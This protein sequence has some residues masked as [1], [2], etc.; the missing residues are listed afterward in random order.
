MTTEEEIITVALCAAGSLITRFLPFTVFSE[1]RPTPSF[2]RYAGKYLPSA[3]FALLVVYCLRNTNLLHGMHGLPEFLS[4][5]AT[6]AL[7]LWKRK[8]F[9]SMAGGTA[10]YMILIRLTENL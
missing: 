3:V 6:A 10:C 1:K 4:V 9:L 5:A 7:H 2:I 8:M